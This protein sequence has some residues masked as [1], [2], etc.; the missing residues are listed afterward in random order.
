MNVTPKLN[1]CLHP[2]QISS[3]VVST[4]TPFRCQWSNNNMINSWRKAWTVWK[5]NYSKA[6]HR[7]VPISSP[8]DQRELCFQIVQS[9]FLCLAFPQQHS[10]ETP[11]LLREWLQ[12][13]W[14]MQLQD[15]QAESVSVFIWLPQA[16][17]WE[18]STGLFWNKTT[19]FHLEQGIFFIQHL[20]DGTITRALKMWAV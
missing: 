20:G 1:L 11:Q 17:S 6:G 9:N 16:G 15:A 2:F 8:S 14:K 7:S 3:R 12:C 13:S 4:A 19:G 10:D 18:A 5:C